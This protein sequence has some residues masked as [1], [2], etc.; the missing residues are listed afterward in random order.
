MYKVSE[1]NYDIIHTQHT[2]V[3]NQVCGMYPTYR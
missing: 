1:V 2:P 3:T